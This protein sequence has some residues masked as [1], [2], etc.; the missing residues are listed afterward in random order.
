MKVVSELTKQT[1]EQETK[2]TAYEQ[3]F[4]DQAKR[5]A[6]LEKMLLFK[7]SAIDQME[8]E[9]SNYRT[10]VLEQG[11][12]KEEEKRDE[13]RAE[14]TLPNHSMP[15]GHSSAAVDEID[16][17]RSEKSNRS[18]EQEEF[19]DLDQRV[20][21]SSSYPTP[22]LNRGLKAGVAFGKKMEKK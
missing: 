18:K 1:K 7:S 17:S 20:A 15:P 13:L 11:I 5:I 12:I 14:G 9:L 6:D 22:A 19:K 2:L 3:M 8:G 16:R 21:K 10:S 4:K